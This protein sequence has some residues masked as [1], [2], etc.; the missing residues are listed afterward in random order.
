ML[1]SPMNVALLLLRSS[2]SARG[3]TLL[4]NVREAGRTRDT[5]EERMLTLI[6]DR[7]VLTR[8]PEENVEWLRSL[9]LDTWL[10]FN[11]SPRWRISQMR[12]VEELV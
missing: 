6:L 11:L 12:G 2:R 9:F 1:S 10:N 5:T 4:S 3:D 8:T 7:E